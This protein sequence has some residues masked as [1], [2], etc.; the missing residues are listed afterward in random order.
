MGGGVVFQKKTSKLKYKVSSVYP[1]LQT[2]KGGSVMVVEKVYVE[3]SIRTLT[4]DEIIDLA[5]TEGKKLLQAY[6]E[7]GKE[8]SLIKAKLS[9]LQIKLLEALRIKSEAT[10]MYYLLKAYLDVEKPVPSLFLFV[11]TGELKR[12]GNAFLMGLNSEKQE[13]QEEEWQV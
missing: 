4:P 3:E 9:L 2:T 10:F 12:I 11:L 13:Y 5:Y 7:S 1:L 6:M 8:E